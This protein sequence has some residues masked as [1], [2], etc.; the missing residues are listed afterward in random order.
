MDV[1]NGLVAPN[2]T[3]LDAANA[4]RKAKRARIMDAA[5]D[6]LCTHPDASY[7][8]LGRHLDV[9]K[10]AA[11]NYA[12]ALVDAGRLKKNGKGWEPTAAE[13]VGQ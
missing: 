8:E 9:S 6:Y 13:G 12:G 4:G 11:S 7:S 10:S 1:Q 2:G 3:N 5:L